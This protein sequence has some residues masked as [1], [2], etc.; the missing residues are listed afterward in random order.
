MKRDWILRFCQEIIDRRLDITWQ[1]A[2]GTRSEAIDDE[3]A[4]LLKRSGM[5]SAAYAP[6]SGSETTRA[7]IKK[8]VQHDRLMASIR[9]AA[10]ADLNICAYM[11]IGFP[12]DTPE[13]LAENLPF[14]RDIARAG[15]RDM[16]TAYYMALPGTELF[17]SLCEQGRIVFD[18]GYFRQVLEG[19][20]PIP[21][22]SYSDALDRPALF[23]W[24]VR[25]VAAFYGARLR[26]AGLRRALASTVRAMGPKSH[27][28]KLETAAR[29]ALKNGLANVAVLFGPRW[30]GRAEERELFAG[31]NAVFQDIWQKRRA[32]GLDP[33]APLDSRELEHRT[34]NHVIQLDHRRRR[35]L[36]LASTA[37]ASVMRPPESAAVHRP[38]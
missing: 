13:H 36:A 22:A 9:A 2:N 1:L 23:Y 16:G 26:K 31:W 20:S 14:L 32:A 37:D 30:L 8:R 34:V 6:E 12:H 10:D 5:I 35:V 38:A 19:L 17:R 21:A 4:R 11:I 18:E 25:Y 3:V 15:V 7:Y 27:E 28:N 29:I 33:P 24:K